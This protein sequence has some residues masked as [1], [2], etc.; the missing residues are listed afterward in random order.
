MNKGFTLIE[1]LGIIIVL[2]VISSIAVV[3]VDKNIKR[4]KVTI[5]STQEANIIESAKTYLVDHPDQVNKRIT[6]S[7][8]KNNGYLDQELKNPMTDKLYTDDTYVLKNDGKYIITYIG[9]TDCNGTEGQTM[10]IVMAG[11]PVIKV[12]PDNSD[13]D[14]HQTIYRENITNVIFE[15][16]INI[17]AGATSWDIS[18]YKNGSVMAWLTTDPSDST[19]YTLHIGGNEGV[20]AN[21]NSSYLFKDFINLKSIVFGNNFD[22]SYVKNMSHMFEN[23]KSLI[24]LPIGDFDTSGVKTMS[25]MF[26]GCANLTN[27]DVSKFD[28]SN[29]TSLS[30]MF[31]GCQS[32]TNLDVSKWKTNKVTT[33]Q[34]TFDNCQSLKSLDVSKWD[35]SKVTSMWFTFS[36]CSSL[37]S[38]DV[39]KWDTSKVRV[40]ARMFQDCKSLTSLDVSN[41]DT[42]AVDNAVSGALYGMGGMFRGCKSLTSLDVSNFN[43]SKVRDFDSMFYNC[44]SLTS[45]DVSKWD[46][47]NAQKMEFMFGDCTSLQHLDVSNWDTSNVKSMD[48][49]FYR[50]SKLTNLDVSKWKTSK[51]TD[52]D[53]LFNSCSGLTSLDVSKWDTSNVKSMYATFIGCSGLTSLD[54]SKW[55]T[56]KVTN[57]QSMFGGCRSLTSLDVSKWNTTSVTNMNAMFAS[58]TKLTSLDLSSFDTSNLKIAGSTGNNMGMFN[59][60][61]NLKTIYV[62]NKFVVSNVTDSTNMFLRA[63]KLVGGNGT[64]YS[65]DHIDKEYARIDTASAPGYFTKKS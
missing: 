56:S 51:V 55:D 54:V 44:T 25:R 6:V 45:L 14:F 26:Y 31:Y 38:L 43:T 1:V 32:L 58:M 3:T 37:T 2:S 35:T 30:Q 16:T 60:C 27:L 9:E 7:T 36:G 62:S 15:N 8:L 11:L 24:N 63:T 41:F 13:A 29:V 50:C 61:I 48:T 65:A 5:C 23:C 22:T 17:P 46:T 12:W 18:E 19:K 42:S 64:K 57:M 28:T 20:V 59:D 47:S 40:M 34:G 49:M 52:M 21:E 10:E 4:G 33:L 53:S 39:S